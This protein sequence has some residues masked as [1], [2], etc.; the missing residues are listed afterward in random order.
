MKTRRLLINNKGFT[1]LEAVITMLIF[2]VGL[3]GIATLQITSV[4]SNSLS[5]N[6]QANTV[7]AME[8]VEEFM[9]ADYTDQRIANNGSDYFT[10]DNNHTITYTIVN[11]DAIPGAKLVNVSATFSATKSLTPQTIELKCFKPFIR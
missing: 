10:T 9:A 4:N 8:Q 5:E 1:L 6:V 3:L 11:D 2:F 7:L